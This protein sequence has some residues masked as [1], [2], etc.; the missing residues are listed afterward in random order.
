VTRVLPLLGLLATAAVAVPHDA[1]AGAPA[2]LAMC[3]GC[4]DRAPDGIR[5]PPAL[6]PEPLATPAD[7]RVVVRVTAA[8][9]P[10]ARPAARAPLNVAPKTSPPASR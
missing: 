9:D 8:A 10:D 6:P 1:V 7:P 2:C 4:D 3:D 5:S